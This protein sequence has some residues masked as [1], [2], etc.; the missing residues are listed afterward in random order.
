MRFLVLVLFALFIWF[1][2]K[3][4]DLQKQPNT[5][6]RTAIKLEEERTRE[7]RSPA[8]AAEWNNFNKD[9]TVNISHE[10]PSSPKEEPVPANKT[11]TFAEDKSQPRHQTIISLQ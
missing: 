6:Q 10:K 11:V 9:I 1:Y 7:R 5:A 3:S 4:K 8:A 2:L